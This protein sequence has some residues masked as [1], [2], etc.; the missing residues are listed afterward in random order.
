MHFNFFQLRKYVLW[1]Y[2]ALS[3]PAFISNNWSIPLNP[4]MGITPCW[5]FHHF[6]AVVISVWVIW[7]NQYSFSVFKLL[8]ELTGKILLFLCVQSYKIVSLEVLVAMCLVIYSIWS[9]R[10]RQLWRRG[11][12]EKFLRVLCCC[13]Y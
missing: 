10:I 1:T 11:E 12:R 4:R 13:C 9:E 7:A 6:L 3:F 2:I 8:I 5:A